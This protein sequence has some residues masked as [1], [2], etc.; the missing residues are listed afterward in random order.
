MTAPITTI[1]PGVFKG[2]GIADFNHSERLIQVD[3]VDVPILDF[4]YH[5]YVECPEVVFG[6]TAATVIM[7][8]R[9]AER[10][11]RN[12][13]LHRV[14][15][16]PPT[17]SEAWKAGPKA[18]H[19]LHV[20]EALDLDEREVIVNWTHTRRVPTRTQEAIEKVLRERSKAK[21]KGE[22]LLGNVID[23]VG[24]GLKINDRIDKYG[25]TR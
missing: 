11:V 18:E 24:L 16:V 9:C 3:M 20:W 12:V 19:Q 21:A 8:A 2:H 13:P 22:F 23:A 4:G 25:R 5:V 6:G 7:L 1:D 15:F 14:T 10:V 17:G